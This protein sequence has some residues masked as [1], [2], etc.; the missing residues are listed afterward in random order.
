[1]VKLLG[2]A[3]AEER[4]DLMGAHTRV[5]IHSPSGEEE[6]RLVSA[7]GHL[8][9]LRFQTRPVTRPDHGSCKLELLEKGGIIT[10]TQ[11]ETAELNRNVG[12]VVRRSL[13]RRFRKGLRSI[14]STALLP[15]RHRG[16]ILGSFVVDSLDSYF[17]TERN[18]WCDSQWQDC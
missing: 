12:A 2:S 5:L 17:F 18:G 11:K 10:H 16:D 15:L 14:Q 7:V 4:L 9:K 3:Q 13:D 1:V 8:A 6:Y